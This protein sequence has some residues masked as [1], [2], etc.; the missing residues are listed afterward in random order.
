MGYQ[1]LT[2]LALGSVFGFLRVSSS[3]SSWLP[4]PYSVGALAG[5]LVV[6]LDITQRGIGA[7]WLIPIWVVL[8]I[9]AGA[10]IALAGGA[11]GNLLGGLYRA[12]RTPH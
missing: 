3:R 10:A 5:S 2:V 9:Y 4:R 7:W 8:G 11:L 12:S 6:A 1:V